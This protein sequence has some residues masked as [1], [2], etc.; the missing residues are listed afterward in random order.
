M[1]Q[2]DMGDGTYVSYDDYMYP[3]VS[4]R[5]CVSCGCTFI[6][7]PQDN[8]EQCWECENGVETCTRGT[9]GCSLSDSQHGA[10]NNDIDCQPQ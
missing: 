8:D 1:I 2:R 6:P 10:R 3:P 5:E 4:D 9:V 7:D